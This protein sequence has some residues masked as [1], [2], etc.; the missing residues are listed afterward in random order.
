MRIGVQELVLSIFRQGK[1]LFDRCEVQ[2]PLFES[3]F[4]ALLL[5]V[6]LAVNDVIKSGKS[7]ADILMQ[8]ILMG[9]GFICK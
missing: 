8:P 2:V 1:G 4:S 7:N 9:I 6:G 3:D 5:I